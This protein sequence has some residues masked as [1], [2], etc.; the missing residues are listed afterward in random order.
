VLAGIFALSLGDG[1]TILHP[2]SKIA[3]Y[4]V[5]LGSGARNCRK[6]AGPLG[7]ACAEMPCMHN[8][9]SESFAVLNE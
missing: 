4:D 1:A 7:S 9:D 3:I 6:A 5:F 2:A 8:L